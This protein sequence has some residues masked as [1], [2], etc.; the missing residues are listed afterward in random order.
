M[1]THKTPETDNAEF[2]K[3]EDCSVPDDLVVTA[4]V[5]RDLE[6]RLA[7]CRDALKWIAELYDD[8][9]PSYQVAMDAYS[10]KCEAAK[11]LAETAPKP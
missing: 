8:G 2:N 6:R 10:M 7:M 3:D 11:A 5:A 9:K 1:N 4:C